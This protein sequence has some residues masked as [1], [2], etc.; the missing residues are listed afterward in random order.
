MERL[1]PSSK[2]DFDKW[3][4]DYIKPIKN[5]PFPDLIQ[6]LRDYGKEVAISD[7][8]QRIMYKCIKSGRFKLAEAIEK[9]YR[10]YLPKFDSVIAFK[11]SLQAL[12]S[13][14]QL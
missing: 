9:K 3:F 5:L 10:N 12:K 2:V 7:K 1:W 14:K 6:E 13:K 8:A 11:F 4:E